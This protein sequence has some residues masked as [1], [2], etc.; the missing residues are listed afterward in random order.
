MKPDNELLQAIYDLAVETRSDVAELKERVTVLEA[1]VAELKADVAELKVNY[2]RL[3]ERVTKL[4][5]NVT[6]INL[7]ME[8]TITRNISIIA[9]SH[10]D[11][12]RKMNE[13]LKSQEQREMA[14]LHIGW[15]EDDVR[16]LKDAVGLTA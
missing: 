14:L 10:L 4:E 8:N 15:L 16:K 11:L 2:E 5:R 3:D 7:Q 12:N 9:E 6:S 1:D 13:I